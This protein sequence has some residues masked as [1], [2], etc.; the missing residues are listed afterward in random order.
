[1]AVKVTA[2]ESVEQVVGLMNMVR[3]P[4]LAQN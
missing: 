4:D 1:M 2:K 3:R